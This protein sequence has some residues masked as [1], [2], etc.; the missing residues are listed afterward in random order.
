MSRSVGCRLVF[1]AWVGL[2]L[3]GRGGGGDGGVV[4]GGRWAGW[5]WGFGV[6]G[7]GVEAMAFQC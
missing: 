2:V 4:R 5:G 7:G 6:R 1:A 3:L